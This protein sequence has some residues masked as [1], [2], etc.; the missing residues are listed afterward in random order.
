MDLTC[1]EHYMILSNIG[2]DCTIVWNSEEIVLPQYDSLFVPFASKN[3]TI[4]QGAH[5]LVSNP[6]K[7]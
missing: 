2:A 1:D 7:D 6:R 5:L 4:K 3:I